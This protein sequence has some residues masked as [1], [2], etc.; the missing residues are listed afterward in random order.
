MFI[1]SHRLTRFSDGNILN[2]ISNGMLQYNIIPKVSP[3][4]KIMPNIVKVAKLLRPRRS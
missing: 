1:Y 2:S 3:I 4:T